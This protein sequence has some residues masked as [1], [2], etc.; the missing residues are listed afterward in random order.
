MQRANVLIAPAIRGSWLQVSGARATLG[1]P[2]DGR[3][4]GA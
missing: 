2:A 1:G 3:I 4:F